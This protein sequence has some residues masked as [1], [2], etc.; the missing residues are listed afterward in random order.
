MGAFRYGKLHDF[1]RTHYD[2]MSGILRYLKKY[3]DTGNSEMLIDVANYALIES[4]RGTGEDNYDFPVV[5][6]LVGVEADIEDYLEA[7][8]YTVRVYQGTKAKIHLACIA[9]FAMFAAMNKV[10][11]KHH[12]EGTDNVELHCHIK[13]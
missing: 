13:V 11:P 2:Y 1:N 10:H 6:L 9:S 12:F 4:V 3:E 7:I 5:H 8:R